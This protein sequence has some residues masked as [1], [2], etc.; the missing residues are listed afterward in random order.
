YFLFGIMLYP[1]FKFFMQY[2]I[3]CKYYKINKNNTNNLNI[4]WND[5]RDVLDLCI[6]VF[7]I[8]IDNFFIYDN[9]SINRVM[10]DED[11]NIFGDFA[12]EI[13]PLLIKLKSANIDKGDTVPI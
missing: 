11:D 9:R 2:R 1:A 6:K 10:D 5:S 7:N 8:E 4:N 3:W 13:Y 12:M